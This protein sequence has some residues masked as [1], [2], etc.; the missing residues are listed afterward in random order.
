V[1]NRFLAGSVAEE[2]VVGRVVVDVVEGRVAVR[3]AVVDVAGRLAGAVAEV[4]RPTGL[5]V[6]VAVRDAVVLV[7]GFFS[8]VELATL[9]L[10]SSVEGV[11]NGARVEAVPAMDMR[12]AVLDIPRFSSP[13]LAIDRG[14][15]S[16]ELL[17]DGRDR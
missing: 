13:E 6:D 8:K 17:T 2:E 12:L 16:A 3:V 15:S 1:L 9:N 7:A 4:R 14:F 5:L 10:R 11:F